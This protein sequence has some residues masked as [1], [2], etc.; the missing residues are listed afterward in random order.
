[1]SFL[2]F[3]PGATPLDPDA[4]AGLLPALTT[5]AELNEFEAVNILKARR[6]AMSSRS[7]LRRDYPT[8]FGLRNLHQRMFDETWKWAGTYRTTDKNL[9]VPAYQIGEQ[10]RNLCA[11]V[12]AQ[13]EYQAYPWPELAVRLHRDL[14]W[15]H[16]FENGNGRHARLAADFLLLYHQQPPLT[17]GQSTLVADDD[18]RQEYLVALR[19]A[20][21][22]DYSRLLRFAQS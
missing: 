8:D 14:V 18:T 6:W 4:A 10:V 5:Q 7:Q 20:D 9:G 13:V 16:P 3:V 11:N 19:E 22:G 17:W 12:R 21:G 2:E 15:I 1:M